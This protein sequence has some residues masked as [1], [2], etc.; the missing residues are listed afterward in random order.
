[1]SGRLALCDHLER[2]VASNIMIIDPISM[3]FDLNGR[4]HV[5]FVV[6]S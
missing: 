4:V 3:P 2:I 6:I 1:M 5:R